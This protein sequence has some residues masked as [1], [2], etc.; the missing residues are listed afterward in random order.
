MSCSCGQNLWGGKCCG[1]GQI[2]TIP[3]T[4]LPA[5]VDLSSLGIYNFENFGAVSGISGQA[6]STAA[7]IT[8]LAKV[9][10]TSPLGGRCWFKMGNYLLIPPPGGFVIPDQV[11]FE[12]ASV[13]AGVPASGGDNPSSGLQQLVM[14]GG[15]GTFFT[16][17]AASH[18][19]GGRYIEK[20][21]F[22]F[23]PLPATLGT[24]TCFDIQ[25][26]WRVAL[27]KCVIENFP[28]A[29]NLSSLNAGL[30]Q[31][32][33]RYNKGPDGGG[34]GGAIPVG[35]GAS[36]FAMVRFNAPQTYCFGPAEL[37][38]LS[39]SNGGP[40]QCVAM[41]IVGGT[42]HVMTRE[43]HVADLSYGYT[44]GFGSSQPAKFNVHTGDKCECWSSVGWMQLQTGGTMTIF[45]EKF[46]GCTYQI[47]QFSTDTKPVWLIDP[48]GQPNSAI[49]GCEW[50]NC[51]FAQGNVDGVEVRGG[52]DLKWKGGHMCGNGAGSFAGF[53][54]TGA[55]GDL[56]LEGI[57][58]QP[59]YPGALNVKAQG[60]AFRIADNALYNGVCTVR[61]GNWR[62]YPSTGPTDQALLIGA[63]A[64][65]PN[66]RLYINLVK[67]YNDGPN[68]T[69]VNI[70]TGTVPNVPTSAAAQG[71]FGPSRAEFSAVAGNNVSLNGQNLPLAGGSLTLDLGPYDVIA[72]VGTFGVNSW[73]SRWG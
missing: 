41:S 6:Q 28:R 72:A 26:G 29:A 32:T 37:L 54:I 65:G 34:P 10:A 59:T 62:G 68:G 38:Q 20:L 17:P 55:A 33:I 22:A 58:M 45:A 51:D 49:A 66:G 21:C 46:T 73:K 36:N 14:E 16:T 70:G 42:D 1:G 39:V 18:T 7:M 2:V 52:Q 23:G 44:W 61:G 8:M 57:N 50:D 48:N 31:V 30:D 35:P 71:F 69:P 67:G 64:F 60:H 15:D 11:T 53:A 56:E 43:V 63:N 9:G 5:N 47:S 4:T 40:K 25:G 13:Q 27:Y 24:T 12:G 3:P 19:S